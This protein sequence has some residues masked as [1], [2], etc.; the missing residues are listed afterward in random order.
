MSN[1]CLIVELF[2][3]FSLRENDII[4][5]KQFYNQTILLILQFQ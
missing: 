3:C 1:Y 2:D 4:T 5:I